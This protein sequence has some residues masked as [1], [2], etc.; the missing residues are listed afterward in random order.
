MLTFPSWREHILEDPIEDIFRTLPAELFF[1]FN[2]AEISDFIFSPRFCVFLEHLPQDLSQKQL[3]VIAPD[4]G[5]FPLSLFF[6]LCR[7]RPEAL[8]VSLAGEPLLQAYGVTQMVGTG[9]TG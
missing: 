3:L 9:Q 8:S 5:E 2:S 6:R 1:F 7:I 4:E